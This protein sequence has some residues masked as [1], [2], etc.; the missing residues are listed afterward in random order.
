MKYL[1]WGVAVVG[2]V[3]FSCQENKKSNVSN[4]Q[5]SDLRFE[6]NRRMV[7]LLDSWSRV[8]NFQTNYFLSG[9]RADFLLS[10]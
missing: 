5:E 7:A 6:G 2:L 10:N 1:Y 9:K 3:F 4:F 8:A